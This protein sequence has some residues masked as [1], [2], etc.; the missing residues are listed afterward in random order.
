ME[1]E[2]SYYGQRIVVTTAPTEKGAWTSRAELLDDKGRVSST[3]EVGREYASED[4]ARR[5][6]LSAAAGVIDRAR[7]SRG[8][9]SA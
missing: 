7:T 6:A 2:E 3:A 4:D 8:K 1:Y 5:A 9:P